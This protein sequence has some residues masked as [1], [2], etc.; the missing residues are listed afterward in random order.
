MTA[1]AMTFH[2]RSLI[3]ALAFIVLAMPKARADASA[4]IETGRALFMQKGC[5]ECHGVLGQGSAS[6]GPALAP[7]PIALSAMQA[8]VHDPK[9]E[10]PVYSKRIL[11]DDEIARIHAYLASLPPNPPAESLA[12]LNDGAP[13]TAQ[14][15]VP[16]GHGASIYAANCAACHGAGGEGG[17]GP[18]LRGIASR[19]GTSDIEARI[20]E[21]SG[22]MPRLYPHVL[23]DEDVRDVAR[24]VAQ[25]R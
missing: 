13:P 3:T 25:L 7:H 18:V 9:G 6:T 14:A 24:Y 16:T 21:P 10:M 11:S 12:L 1:A 20:R 5:Y 4:D 17:V 15:S 22:I 2:S 19:Y 23:N 8:Y